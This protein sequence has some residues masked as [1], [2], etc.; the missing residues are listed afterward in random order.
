MHQFLSLASILLP[1]VLLVVIWFYFIGISRKAQRD[2]QAGVVRR[3]IE[4]KAPLPIW[5]IGFVQKH[6][7]VFMATFFGGAMWI[8]MTVIPALLAFEDLTRL[9]VALGMG[10][11][12]W[13]AGGL[14]FA[15]LVFFVVVR[16]FRLSKKD[17]DAASKFD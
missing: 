11:L 12:Q 7:F 13:G 4:I 1:S 2:S 16:P 3:G 15:T 17:R 10:A 9:A 6:P 14:L 8:V 5:I